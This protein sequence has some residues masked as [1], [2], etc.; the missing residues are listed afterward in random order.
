LTSAVV[1]VAVFATA[2]AIRLVAASAA[3]FPATQPSAYYVDVAAAAIEGRG[4][5]ADGIWSFASPPIVAPKPA[6]DLWLPMASLVAMPFMATLGIGLPAAQISHALLGALLAPL[7]WWIARDAAR[8]NNLPGRRVA[9][10]AATAGL[11]IA[12]LGPLIVAVMAPDSTTPFAVFA[13]AAV[14]VAP[15]ALGGT[16]GRPSVIAAAALGALLGLAYLSRQEAVYVATAYLAV[17]LVLTKRLPP[18][19]RGRYLLSA[20]G[21][22]VAVGAL[23]VLPWL[24]R[25]AVTFGSAFAGQAV[26]NAFLIEAADV[27]AWSERPTA[28]RYFAQGLTAV[29]GNVVGALGHNAVSVLLLAAAPISIVG[30]A[31]LVALRRTVA[32]RRVSALQLLVIASVLTYIATSVAF[33]VATLAGTY[34][35]S[36][37]PALVALAVLA[38]LGADAALTRLARMRA[39]NRANEWLSPLALLAIAF[40][41]AALQ[42]VV[43][44]H[45]S[46]TAASRIAPAVAT[47]G[48][49]GVVTV[50][51][52]PI[53][54]AYA[55]GRPVIVLPDEPPGSVW[56][57]ASH[58]DAPLVVIFGEHGRYPAAMS[59]TD[60][61]ERISGTPTRFRVA[62]TCDEP[63][64]HRP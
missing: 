30:L 45:Q 33:P 19:H 52:E 61:F 38:A 48:P 56:N 55:T 34:L 25:N 62:R 36:A 18:A 7:A 20:L 59:N 11:L 43:V 22:V 14:A 9:W 16:S 51:D 27:F 42:I 47:A 60:C 44:A 54:L 57:L 58:F 39:W 10:I 29:T 37:G 5:V 8:R 4:L 21:P 1:P 3:D 15:G 12:M 40:P 26:E 49:L 24:A 2:L 53:W 13:T 46:E 32:L 50:S 63:G 31:A 28:E 6:F 64:A 35:H 23:T 17:T 41:L